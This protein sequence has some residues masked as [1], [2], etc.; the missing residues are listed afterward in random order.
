[1]LKT[2][3]LPTNERLMHL[4]SW[5]IAV[6]K[7]MTM[8]SGARFCACQDHSKQHLTNAIDS[9]VDEHISAL[10]YTLR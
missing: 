2:N 3:L 4:G 9:L 7:L 5:K 1:M 8:L 10:S 6:I